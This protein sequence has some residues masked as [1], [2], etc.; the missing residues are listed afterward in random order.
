MAGEGEGEDDE[1]EEWIMSSEWA[2]HFRSSPSVQRYLKDAI[3]GG[4]GK[5]GGIGGSKSRGSGGGSGGKGAATRSGGKGKT[6]HQQPGSKG[7]GT[8]KSRRA[9]AA[10]GASSSASTGVGASEDQEETAKDVTDAKESMELELAKIQARALLYAEKQ[11]N[12]Q[13][14]DAIVP[15]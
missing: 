7:G 12:R 15:S 10:G 14:E 3:G 4:K 2:E 13:L 9:A 1:E 11:K 5:R 6:K 8:K